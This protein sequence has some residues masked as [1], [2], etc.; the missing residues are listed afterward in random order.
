MVL[1]IEMYFCTSL[2]LGPL[3]TAIRK[4]NANSTSLEYYKLHWLDKTFHSSHS[5]LRWHL[6]II[7]IDMSQVFIV[8]NCT[9]AWV[10][11][12]TDTQHIINRINSHVDI[13]N[14][15]LSLTWIKG[16]VW[17]VNIPYLFKPFIP[18]KFMCFHMKFM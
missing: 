8:F 5:I 4:P 11:F 2:P 16:C 18:W 9:W 10:V 15:S 17:L 13:K 12:N 6:T 3:V 14:C 7:A 1:I